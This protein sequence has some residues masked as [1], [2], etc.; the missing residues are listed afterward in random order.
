MTGLSVSSPFAFLTITGSSSRLSL[1]DGPRGSLSS[2]IVPAANMRI[3]VPL[4]VM[5][6][7]DSASEA[8]HQ[9][10]AFALH[11]IIPQ[12]LHAHWH[13]SAAD[14]NG[15]IEVPHGDVYQLVQ[16]EL[17]EFLDGQVG[18]VRAERQPR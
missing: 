18:L 14:F 6:H 13:L 15:L 8:F 10:L 3:S 7:P 1:G 5:K 16:D 11:D 4:F 12:H 9:A 2:K 17:V